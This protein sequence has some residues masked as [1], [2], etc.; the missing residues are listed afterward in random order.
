MSTYRYRSLTKT[1]VLI[2]SKKIMSLSIMPSTR[3]RSHPA[4]GDR[5]QGAMRPV[6]AGPQGKGVTPIGVGP[7]HN[8]IMLA[9]G[10]ISEV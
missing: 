1:I 8:R 3:G 10:S 9:L 7:Y 5:R 2:F 6:A 4:G